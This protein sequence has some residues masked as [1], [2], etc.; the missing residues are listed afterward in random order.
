M[1]VFEFF[2]IALIPA[3]ISAVIAF[4]ILFWKEKKIEPKRLEKNK[5]IEMTEKKLQCY[6]HL[7][8]MLRIA[9]ERGKNW[10]SNDKNP[11]SFVKPYGTQKLELFFQENY[12]LLSHAVSDEYL[13][14]VEKDTRFGLVTKPNESYTTNHFSINFRDLEQT[15]S[16]EYDNLK[17][18]FQSLTGYSFN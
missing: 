3:I 1:S 8:G 9:K 12:Y 7:L 13:K 14:L 16:A 5:R 17:S 6:G 2:N 4:S 18:Y 15:T 10:N 11:H